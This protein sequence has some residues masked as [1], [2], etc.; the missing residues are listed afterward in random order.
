MLRFYRKEPGGGSSAVIGD[1]QKSCLHACNLK[2]ALELRKYT[3]KYRKVASIN[4]SCF[5]LEAPFTIYSFF[6]QLKWIYLICLNKVASKLRTF[7]IA[8]SNMYS[9]PRMYVLETC[10]SSYLPQ[11]F[12]GGQR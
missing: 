3:N 6:V 11:R 9:N 8:L 12:W 10:V 1:V 4:T 2:P 7:L 5:C